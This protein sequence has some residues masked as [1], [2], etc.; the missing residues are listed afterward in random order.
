MKKHPTPHV[1]VSW[2]ELLDK[3]TILQI[4]RER[5]TG[6]ALANVTRELDALSVLAGPVLAGDEAARTLMAR[7]KALNET[8]WDIEDRIRAKEAAGLFDADFVALARSVYQRNDERAALKRE[9]NRHLGS[10]LVEEKS[11]KS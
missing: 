11:Y 1:P 3:I 7:L 6:A 8:L 4:K 5:L 10:E 9:L 2:G